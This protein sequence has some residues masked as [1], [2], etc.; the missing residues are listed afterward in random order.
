MNAK[1][2]AANTRKEYQNRIVRK[3]TI[4]RQKIKMEIK[5]RKKEK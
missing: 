2:N 1:K 3:R 4:R 5:I